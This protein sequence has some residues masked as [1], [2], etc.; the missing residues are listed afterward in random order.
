M[1]VY[2]RTA[3]KGTLNLR[4]T[5]GGRIIAQIPNGTKLEAQSEGEWSKVGYNG[6]IGYVKSNKLAIKD[7]T[8]VL[9]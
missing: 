2:V 5:P 6:K 4:E 8:K 7:L 3:N 9:N 1:I